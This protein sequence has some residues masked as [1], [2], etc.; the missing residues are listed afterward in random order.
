MAVTVRVIVVVAFI[1][2][3][4]RQLSCNECYN[5]RAG[6]QQQRAPH[7]SCPAGTLPGA[8]KRYRTQDI[9]AAVFGDVRHARQRLHKVQVQRIGLEIERSR[10]TLMERED[11]AQFHGKV[12]VR[13]G[14]LAM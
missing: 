12:F 9:V 11:T 3:F 13:R 8:D 7:S 2:L 5:T 14:V 6:S 4:V 1:R 10:E